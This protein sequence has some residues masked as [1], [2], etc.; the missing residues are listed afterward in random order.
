MNQILRLLLKAL[1]QREQGWRIAQHLLSHL[2]GLGIKTTRH[3]L[4]QVLVQGA[5][6][7]ADR[8]VVVIQDHQQ[9]T[10]VG[11]RIVHGFVGHAGGQRTVADDGHSFALAACLFGRH[12]HAKGGRNAGGGM[13]GAESVVNTFFAARKPTQAA[14]LAQGAH[15]V[16]A[17][18]EHFVGISLMTDVPNESIF[19]RVVDVMQGNGQLNRAQIGA[20]MAACLRDRLNQTPTKLF[21]QGLQILTRQLPQVRRR[22]NPFQQGVHG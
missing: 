11:A 22:L 14:H 18:R 8:H 4:C 20:E 3:Q 19:R 2:F 6:W 12:G 7:R 9:I 17:A 10:I 5:N 16:Q 1:G 13:G 21:S 15:L